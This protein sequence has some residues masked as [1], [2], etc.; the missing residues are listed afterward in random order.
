MAYAQGT[1]PG[2]EDMQCVTVF[3]RGPK[4]GRQAAGGRESCCLMGPDL[5]LGVITGFWK[6]TVVMVAQHCGC[7]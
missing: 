1:K 5:L 3:T 7:D 6:Y 2:T 4:R